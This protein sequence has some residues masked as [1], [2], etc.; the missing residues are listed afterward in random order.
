[1]PM[2]RAVCCFSWW[3]N[4]KSSLVKRCV[5]SIGPSQTQYSVMYSS[6][7]PVCCC[8]WSVEPSESPCPPGHCS[9]DSSQLWAH[10]GRVWLGA[11]AVVIRQDI[12]RL[13]YNLRKER[14]LHIFM[15]FFFANLTAAELF[16]AGEITVFTSSAHSCIISLS[17]LPTAA[18]LFLLKFWPYASVLQVLLL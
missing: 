7:P 17:L 13:L 14:A 8:Y 5:G 18:M 11:R 6:T 12:T 9:S 16:S 3:V 10:S 2:C 1:M 4:I 15:S